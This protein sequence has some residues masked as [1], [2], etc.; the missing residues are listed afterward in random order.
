MLK[1]PR[2]TLPSLP[3]TLEDNA[4]IPVSG[5][6]FATNA[7]VDLFLDHTTST[8]ALPADSGTTESNG[9]FSLP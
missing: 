2:A 7:T 1:A 3:V 9:A 6:G 5:A 4:T 8:S